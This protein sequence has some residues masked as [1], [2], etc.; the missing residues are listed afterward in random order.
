MMGDRNSKIKAQQTT[1]T[2][3]GTANS[4][5]QHAKNDYPPIRITEGEIWKSS[6]LLKI[7]QSVSHGANQAQKHSSNTTSN[8]VWVRST[9]EYRGGHRRA[10]REVT[11][12]DR[13][14]DGGGVSFR[15]YRSACGYGVS[16]RG[17]GTSTGHYRDC[18]RLEPCREG[19]AVL[20]GAGIDGETLEEE[21]KH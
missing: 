18:V 2:N 8:V 13:V 19:N 5:A 4:N 9:R 10:A 12:V 6:A 17:D 11:V 3:E 16:T 15:N 14:N 21:A 20:G 1:Q 7:S